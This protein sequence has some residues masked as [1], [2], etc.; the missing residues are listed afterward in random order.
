MKAKDKICRQM[1]KL[2][3]A[4]VMRHRPLGI[5]GDSS[6]ECVYFDL[7]IRRMV[8]EIIYTSPEIA[9]PW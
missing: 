6:A 9:H 5:I 8:E 1:A 2:M 4:Q 7:G 3:A